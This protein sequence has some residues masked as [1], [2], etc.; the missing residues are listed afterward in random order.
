MS[1]APA[2]VV[3]TFDVPVRLLGR[4]K[5]LASA[6]FVLAILLLLSEFAPRTTH[7]LKNASTHTPRRLTEH[8]FRATLVSIPCAA[9][10]IGILTIGTAITSI[11]AFKVSAVSVR[12]ASLRPSRNMAAFRLPQE[13]DAGC[14]CVVALQTERMVA[15]RY[16]P[17]VVCP[18]AALRS[19]NGPPISRPAAFCRPPR[20]RTARTCAASPAGRRALACC[21]WWAASSPS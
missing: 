18:S 16:T 1:A 12:P 8:S 17:A 19:I 6:V 15:T 7:L 13:A 14:N 21:W 20:S 3:P 9:G 4:V 11:L 2:S 5:V 10:N